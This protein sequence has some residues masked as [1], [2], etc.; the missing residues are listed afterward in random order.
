VKLVTG[1]DQWVYWRGCRAIS[2]EENGKKQKH[3]KLTGQ[4][5]LQTGIA[6]L[7]AEGYVKEA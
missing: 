1:R 7:F 2:Y 6:V 4:I 5:I 3:T